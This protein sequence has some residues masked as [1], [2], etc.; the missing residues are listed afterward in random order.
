MRGVQTLYLGPGIVFTAHEPKYE[1]SQVQMCCG[2]HTGIVFS[3]V[4]GC[5]LR[6]IF[7]DLT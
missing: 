6:P 5:G 1:V 2:R 3:A 7:G 4:V